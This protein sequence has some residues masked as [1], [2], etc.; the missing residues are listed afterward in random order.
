MLGHSLAGGHHSDTFRVRL[1]GFYVLE[2]DGL[3]GRRLPRSLSVCHIRR[4]DAQRGIRV[5]LQWAA[6]ADIGPSDAC[7]RRAARGALGN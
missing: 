4:R 7:E 3:A 5:G 1:F 2:C 6:G